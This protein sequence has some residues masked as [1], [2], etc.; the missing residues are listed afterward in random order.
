MISAKKEYEVGKGLTH[1]QEDFRRAGANL[2]AALDEWIEW[3]AKKLQ[4]VRNEIATKSA[5]AARYATATAD[6]ELTTRREN[7]RTTEEFLHRLF[8][9][10]FADTNSAAE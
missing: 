3:R 4:T 2:I 6:A 7:L 8:P 5:P 10:D 1:A 9:D